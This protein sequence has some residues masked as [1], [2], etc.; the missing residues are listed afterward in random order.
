MSDARRPSRRWLANGEGVLLVLLAVE[1]AVFGLLGDRFLSRTNAFEVVRLGV[2]VGLLAVA[3]TAVIVTGGIDLSVGSLMGLSAV[4]FGWLCVAC[5]WPWHL[6]A[7][8]TLAVG[9]LA[10]GLNGW[11]IT[12]LRVPPLIVTLATWSLYRGLAEGATGA[13][14]N[15][16]DLPPRFLWLGQGYV[17]GVVP[18]QLPLFAL[19][20]AAY[21][22]LLHRTAFGRTLFAIGHSPGAARHAGVPTARNVALVYVLC[23]LVTALA[24]LVYVARLGQA[25]AD[26]GQGYELLAITAAVLGGTSI[27]GGRGTVLGTFLGLLSI[28]VLENGLR[29]S[30][31][32]A[33][34]SGILVGLLLLGA[35]GAQRWL[36]APAGPVSE[37]AVEMEMKNSQVAA[38]CATMVACAALVAG[39]NWSLV[40]RLS[41]RVTPA[42]TVAPQAAPASAP[43]A[44]PGKRP[45]VAMMPKSKGDPYF[46]SCREGAEKAAQEL[47]V[48]LLWDGP[49]E[50]DAAKQNEVVEAWITKGV[51]AV[52]V[53]VQNP[54]A[55]STVLR[56]ARAKGIKVVTWDADAKEDARDVLINQATPE[57][58]GFTLT[59]E[60]ARVL[61]GKGQFAII[62]STLTAANQNEWIK[63][64]KRRLEKY[65]GLEL[66]VIKPGEDLLDRAMDETKNVL[67]AYPEVKLVMAISA[68]AVPGAAEAVKQAGR[69][70]VKVVGLSLPNMCKPYIHSG[71]IDCIVL[72]KTW[73][74]GYLTVQA[75]KALVDGTLKPGAKAFAAGS[76]GNIEISGSEVL[77]GKPFVF[78][79]QNVDQFDF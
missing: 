34:L 49:T 63:H 22:V 64:I 7:L 71:V 5:H 4:V 72:W 47:G 23:G 79:Q 73:D 43:A 20:V 35:I 30:G 29:L 66:A 70:D 25:K 59:D 54:E 12:R 42:A 14:A 78:N 44:A 40:S 16:T 2:E 51:D 36:S 60:A 61:G 15:Y 55:I 27:E 67:K 76:L 57:G 62:T 74:L 53:S 24:T 56:K 50:T 46:V 13:I 26:A 39:S 77:L 68:P 65:P 31:L 37:A 41:G 32:P 8:V 52:A 33:E 10:G 48:E 45:V 6:A 1:V 11:L 9:A 3:L 17:G 18:A 19:V 58:I 38:L 69:D 75:A 21:A 28:T